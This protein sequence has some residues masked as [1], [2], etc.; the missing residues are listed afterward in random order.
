MNEHNQM[1]KDRTSPRPGS[2]AVVGHDVEKVDGIALATG[3]ALYAGDYEVR[4]TLVGKILPS[5]HA[6]ARIRRIDVSEAQAVPGVHAVLTWKDLPRVPHTTAG[7]GYPEPSPYDSFVLDNK[8]RFVGDR[9]AAVAADTEEAADE[10]LRK[11]DVDY[12][13]LEPVLDPRKAMDE[14]APVIH[15]EPEAHVIIPVRYEPQRNL[16]AHVAAEVGDVRTAFG[17]PDLL[18]VENEFETQYAQHCPIEPHVVLAYPDDRGRLVIVTSTQ[19]PFH[20]RR[21]VAQALELPVRKIRVIKPRIGGGFGAKQEVLLEQVCAALAL[22]AN[23]PVRITY[24]RRE[25]FI[26]ART[27]HPQIVRIKA[28]VRRD[29]TPRAIDFNVLMNTGAYGAHALTVASNTGSKNLPLYTW[30]DMR[31]EANVVYTNLPVG[32]AYR[33][34][35]VTRRGL[36]L[37]RAP[38]MNWVTGSAWIRSHGGGTITFRRDRAPR[39]SKS[40]ARASPAYRSPSARASSTAASSSVP[41]PSPGRRSARGL[42]TPGRSGEAWAWP[43]SCRAAASRTSIC[44]PQPSR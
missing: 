15:D 23:R 35:G 36:S 42:E 18:V 21:L 39:F 37:S 25:E 1:A 40:W 31:F 3:R 32:G 12:E 6:H 13:I 16:A 44:A 8:V 34:Y 2:F 38:S 30:E 10:A 33:G 11:I 26:S 29:G 9:V 41:R 5:P 24:T 19:V 17:E 43:R 14:G 7:Q 27:R 28:A 20:V 4:G 22:K